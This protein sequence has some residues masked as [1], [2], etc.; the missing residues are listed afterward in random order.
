MKTRFHVCRV[1]M[2]ATVMSVCSVLGLSFGD[3]AAGVNSIFSS[4]LMGIVA[5]EI[6]YPA[7]L[8]IHARAV[9]SAPC[10]DTV[11]MATQSR[12]SRPTVSQ[13]KIAMI[14]GCGPF[15][16][17]EPLSTYSITL[18]NLSSPTSV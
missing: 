14:F 16:F 12:F 3:T 7:V 9:G 2:G 10:V 1:H 11:R 17:W 18:T 6:P 5:M 13:T 8:L 4:A 15:A